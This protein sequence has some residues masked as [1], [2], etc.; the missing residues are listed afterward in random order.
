[1][2]APHSFSADWI[3]HV[4]NK[5][6]ADR[7]LVE[8]AIRALSLLEGLAES[9]LP[10]VFKGGTALMLIFQEPRRLSIDIDI[11]L[12]PD[13]T[14]LTALLQQVA[15]GKNFSRIEEQTRVTGSVPK[16]HFKFYYPSAVENK[17]SYIL[18]DIL[19]E[20]VPYCRII[21][22]PIDNVFLS[23][24]G[25]NRVVKVP[26]VN[27]LIADKL[28]AFAPQ[29]VGVPYRKGDNECGMEIIKQLYDIGLL[30][31]RAD[32]IKTIVAV[33]RTIVQQEIRYRDAQ[34]LVEDILHD[35]MDHALSICFRQGRNNVEYPVLVRGIKQASSHIFS[36]SYHLEKAILSAA[37]AFYLVSLIEFDGVTIEKYNIRHWE[38]MTD[39]LFNDYEYTKLN[40]LK[41]SNPEAFF[42]LYL[43]LN[44]THN[45][46]R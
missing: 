2:I 6:K 20:Q 27:N 28:T 46:G 31:D 16:G 21:E 10:F 13:T 35:T 5:Y 38:R 3:I 40:K 15:F 24:E 30:F 44:I 25:E 45:Q 23:T 9:T 36:E 11:I 43:A 39:W 41:K 37:K 26:D 33:Y 4:S 19:F 42:Y 17:E 7:I 12:P 1:M 14:D 22:R 18:L 29:T 34:Y 32:D 8:K